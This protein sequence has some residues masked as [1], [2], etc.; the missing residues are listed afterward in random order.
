MVR[1]DI[2]IRLDMLVE[3]VNQARQVLKDLEPHK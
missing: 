2:D 3:V 1:R